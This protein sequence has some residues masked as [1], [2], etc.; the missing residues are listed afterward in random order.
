MVKSVFQ[1]VPYI[2]IEK[3]RGN[4]LMATTTH[5]RTLDPADWDELRALA[6]QMVDDMLTHLETVRDR[7]VWQPMPDE[8]RA[9]FN[10]PLP[11][12]AEGA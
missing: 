8:A 11:E 3:L 6:H 4:N 12:Q 9:R 7:P 5:E 1:G 2:V 10:Q